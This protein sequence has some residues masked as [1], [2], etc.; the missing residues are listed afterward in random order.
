MAGKGGGRAW[1]RER[2]ESGSGR[3]LGDEKRRPT[4]C[5]QFR[6][7]PSRSRHARPNKTPARPQTSFAHQQRTLLW[8]GR[9]GCTA[10][11][12]GGGREPYPERVAPPLDPVSPSSPWSRAPGS[13]RCNGT[14]PESALG[15]TRIEGGGR[16]ASVAVA[17]SVR[18]LFRYA[19]LAPPPRTP[20]PPPPPSLRSPRALTAHHIILV[21]AQGS[22]R[23]VS[24]D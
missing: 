15:A 19:G 18:D 7:P 17:K 13:T 21:H 2:G 4:R 3:V 11:E 12:G 6:A 16:G 8:G 22:G 10:R 24:V 1:E 5:C 23:Y 20:P 14:A 9:R